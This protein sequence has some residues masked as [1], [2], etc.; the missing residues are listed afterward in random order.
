MHMPTVLKIFNLMFMIHTR[1]HGFP[2][3]TV[4][5]G[6]PRSHEAMAKIRIDTLTVIEADRFSRKDLGLILKVA[7]R[8]QEEWMEVWNETREG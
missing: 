7:E 4:Y 2:H 1:D 6:T 3:V 8:Y 5:D